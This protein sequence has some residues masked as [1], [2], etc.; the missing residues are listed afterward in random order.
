MGASKTQLQLQV[1]ELKV[2]TEE[3]ARALE[4]G[5]V[6]GAV[7]VRVASLAFDKA[8]EKM[9]DKRPT[10]PPVRDKDVEEPAVSRLEWVVRV[11]KVDHAG[12]QAKAH[13]SSHSFNNEDAGRDYY[14]RSVR[15]HRSKANR[16][17]ASY[18]VVLAS[19]DPRDWKKA[20]ERGWKE[21]EST[22]VRKDRR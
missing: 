13:S 16:E 15:A 3:L 12:C 2:Q 5:G 6:D 7:E 1:I 4:E 17:D 18:A 8:L 19:Q 14:A 20:S 22:V 10:D 9:G 21:V 11:W